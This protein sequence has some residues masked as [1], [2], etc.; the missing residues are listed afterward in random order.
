MTGL[1]DAMWAAIAP[2]MPWN[3]RN[4][5]TN[6]RI[7]P[8]WFPDARGFWYRRETGADIAFMLVDA[9]TGKTRV[10]FDTAALRRALSAVTTDPDT[11][12][13]RVELLDRDGLIGLDGR[14][15]D[16]DG[17]GLVL[18]DL[19]R[20]SG[21]VPTSP[22]GM[23]ALF[24]RAGDLWVR[25][26]ATGIERRLTH[27][28]EPHFE[29]A[30]SPDQNLE[31]IRIARLGITL[32]PIAQWAPDGRHVLTY[33][34]DERAVRSLPMVQN[35]PDDGSRRPVLHDLRIA[36][37]GD[38][39]VPMAHQAVIDTETG[40][41]VRQQGGPVHVTETSLIER[42][43]TWWSADSAR[44]FFVDHD[45]YEK[46]IALVEMDRATG[47]TREI[48]TETSDH[49]VDV[50]ME[51][52]RRP[53]IHILD[54]T[55]EA[56]WFSQR[57]G[58]AHLYLI[59]LHDGT[60]KAQIT[61]GDWVVRDLLAVDEVNR[62]VFFL[63]GG[64]AENATPYQRSLCRADLDGGG[65]TVLTPDAGDND[66][67]MQGVGWADLVAR[68][69]MLGP[70][71]SALSPDCAYFVH[72]FAPKDSLPVSQLRRR[73]GSCVADLDAAQSTA[74]DLIWPTTFSTTAADGKT[75]IFAQVW[76][77]EGD[78][79]PASVPLVEMIYPGPQCI[80]QTLSP[81][82]ADASEFFKVALA[83]ALVRLGMG[84]VILD[85][86]GTPFREKA[87]HDLC[88]GA[89]DNP[90]HL[91]D[92]AKALTDL[93]AAH[94]EI[95]PAR[96]AIMGHSAGGHAAARAVLDYPD[97]WCAAI[98]TAGS[99]DP[100]LYNS[101]WPEKW[102]GR[103][104]QHD[105][106][107]TNYDAADNASRAKGLRGALLLGHGDLDDN[108]HPAQTQKLAAALIAAGKSF[109]ML[110]TPNDDHFT[111]PRNPYVVRRQIDFLL[112]HLRPAAGE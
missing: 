81:F 107:S 57:D 16:F 64:I 74:N 91:D 40:T 59:D 52:G 5:F 101:C 14:A 77:P 84:V 61:Q 87:L 38:A 21:D 25:D 85:G 7:D 55:D 75:E 44:V 48:I 46:R 108:V 82:P 22:D 65:V 37:T 70:L 97:V 11:A 56:I 34:L 13:A 29:W 68:A 12:L 88:H 54:R 45:R 43:E 100:R 42:A 26:V 76:L 8:H 96:V 71:P 36:F 39:E 78:H 19:P 32:P 41:I 89:L 30:K 103:L 20:V 10:A 1:T 104:V 35:V 31:T 92:H 50:N 18:R 79:A 98:A 102:Q 53:N 33:Q 49:F 4:S 23:R 93:C 110:I 62:Q 105:D 9:E 66:V 6:L 73:D 63:T 72:T 69:G 51:Y 106:G 47:A 94:P 86:R 3:L 2:A 17:Q 112:R 111:F 109:E 67:A 90:G 15:Y 24:R 80:E 60:I 83:G 28:A 27:S 99:H 95:D 58:W